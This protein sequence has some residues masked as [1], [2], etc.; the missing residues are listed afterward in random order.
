PTGFDIHFVT[1]RVGA[2]FDVK[3]HLN[4][5]QLEILQNPA[6]CDLLQ[7]GV[8]LRL[9]P[10]HLLVRRKRPDG[11]E[12]RIPEMPDIDYLRVTWRQL[13]PKAESQKPRAA[14]IW[15]QPSSRS[16]A[17]PMRCVSTPG[18]SGGW[19]FG[20]VSQRRMC[21][22]ACRGCSRIAGLR[23]STS[24]GRKLA[25]SWSCAARSSTAFI[26]R[27]SASNG[28]ISCMPAA[29]HTWSGARTNV[30]SNL[31]PGRKRWSLRAVP[32][33]LWRRLARTSSSL[34]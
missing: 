8:V 28:S 10:P 25:A 15:M 11:G 6:K 18:S 19:Q 23:S 20:S 14:P 22:S 1:F 33:G 29:A 12:E 26:L 17:K 24:K 5:E 3:G 21:C 27:T 7:H 32:C 13:P 4:Q 9:S 16:A 34:W 31:R 2:R 30:C